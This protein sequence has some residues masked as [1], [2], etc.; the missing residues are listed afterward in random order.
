MKGGGVI[1]KWTK[2][3]MEGGSG[4]LACVY[5]RFLKEK[6]WDFQDEVL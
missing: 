3:N 4:V 1:E 5:V 2:A 6:C